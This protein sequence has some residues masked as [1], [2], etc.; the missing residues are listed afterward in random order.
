MEY[1]SVR[2]DGAESGAFHVV[3]DGELH[4]GDADAFMAEAYA[5]TTKGRSCAG[6][7]RLRRRAAEACGPRKSAVAVAEEAQQEQEHVDEVK[8]QRERAEQSAAADG[9]AVVHGSVFAHHAEL[10]GVEGGEAGE[11]D[12]AEHAD[13]EVHG[14][15]AEE[16]VH[17]AGQQNAPQAHHE[18]A[19]H[20]GEITLGDHTEHAHAA[21]HACG[22]DEGLSHGGA[23]IDQQHRAEEH[24]HE[25]GVQ[26]EQARGRTGGEAVHPCRDI[27]GQ[28]DDGHHEQNHE[29]GVGEQELHDG[30]VG[31]REHGS[32]GGDAQRGGHPQIDLLHEEGDVGTGVA[33]HLVARSIIHGTFLPKGLMTRFTAKLCG[34]ILTIRLLSP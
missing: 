4:N 10:L 22:D 8:V 1:Q 29:N 34:F 14:S 12:H 5:G 3:L 11:D 18:E 16:G 24:A 33:L 23:G 6:P 20:A 26:Q 21:E 32:Q 7:G 17:D 30:H 2:R 13:G 19:S 15:V 25:R 27:H 9:E 28:T 31:S